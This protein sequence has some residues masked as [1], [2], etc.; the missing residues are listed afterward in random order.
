[1]SCLRRTLFYWG[2]LKTTSGGVLAERA[3][4]R[5]QIVM[6]KR[7]FYS[8]LAVT[9]LLALALLQV[10]AIVDHHFPE[11]QADHMHIYFD[12][13]VPSH[14][15]PYQVDH[16]H[17]HSQPDGQLI[18]GGSQPTSAARDMVYIASNNGIYRSFT[19]STLPLT[20][21]SLDFPD[22]GDN[23]PLFAGD[24]HDRVPSEAFITP[25]EKPPRE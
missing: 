21:A 23:S 24:R 12:P 8:T 5:V 11:R 14:V 15:H 13:D 9:L 18:L 25:P 16:V 4:M 17:S 7:A 22:Q 6:L 2:W 10:G 19:S 20:S 1:M 3:Q